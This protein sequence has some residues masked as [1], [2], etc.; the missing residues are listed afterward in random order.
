MI[1]YGKGSGCSFAGTCQDEGSMVSL[2]V[3]GVGSELEGVTSRGQDMTGLPFPA[4]TRTLH[5]H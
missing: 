4:R 3:L 1:C 2:L 5:P